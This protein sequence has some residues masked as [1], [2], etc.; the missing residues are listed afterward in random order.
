M[1][2]CYASSCPRLPALTEAYHRIIGSSVP[3][4]QE[5]ELF[6]AARSCPK[7]SNRC[8][9]QIIVS[10]INHGYPRVYH[11]PPKLAPAPTTPY[12]GQRFYTAGALTGIPT[13]GIITPY[14]GLRRR[15]HGYSRVYPRSVSSRPTTGHGFIPLGPLGVAPPRR[16]PPWHGQH[17]AASARR[18]RPGHICLCVVLSCV[19]WSFGV[20]TFLCL[21]YTYWSFGV[22]TLLRLGS[23]HLCLSV[24]L[25]CPC[26]CSL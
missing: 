15:S 19:C 2:S 9:P 6:G 18:L 25:S 7:F 5:T 20:Y 17:L 22:Y 13:V 11:V 10:D 8:V 23:T 4:A 16:L 1:I 12:R 14:R 26:C 21:V 3:E 24:V